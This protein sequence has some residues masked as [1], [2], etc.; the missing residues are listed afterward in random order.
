MVYQSLQGSSTEKDNFLSELGLQRIRRKLAVFRQAERNLSRT[1]FCFSALSYCHKNE[2]Q[3]F[4]L[5]AWEVLLPPFGL[6]LLSGLWKPFEDYI[7]PSCRGGYRSSRRSQKQRKQ[8]DSQ[9]ESLQQPA[10]WGKKAKGEARS[11]AWGSC[12]F[13]PGKPQN[14]QGSRSWGKARE[15]K[16]NLLVAFLGIFREMIMRFQALWELS[17]SI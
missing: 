9:S 8:E 2:E 17:V 15:Q 10:S 6:L 5:Q 12:Q 14:S 1:H 16:H 7:L 11:P 3:V 13:L 4:I